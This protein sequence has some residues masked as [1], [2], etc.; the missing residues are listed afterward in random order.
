M[1]SAIEESVFGSYEDNFVRNSKEITKRCWA[2]IRQDRASAKLNEKPCEAAIDRWKQELEPRYLDFVAMA[3]A[4]SVAGLRV[5]QEYGDFLAGLGNALTWANQWVEAE[6]LMSLALSYLPPD[7]PARER[8][9]SAISRFAGEASQERE[10][11]RIRQQELE[12]QRFESLC[13][14]ASSDISHGL[15]LAAAGASIAAVQVCERAYQRYDK[16]VLPW[17]STIRAADSEVG[18][19]CL[20]AKAAAARCLLRI[21]DGFRRCDEP[22]RASDL[23]VVAAELAAQDSEILAE[24]AR[25]H[26]SLASKGPSRST[27]KARGN[28]ASPDGEGEEA[29]RR[30]DTDIELFES[31]CEKVRLRATRSSMC[32]QTYHQYEGVISP[33]LARISAVESITS[34]RA[35]RARTAAASCLLVIAEG[36]KHCDDRGKASSIVAAAAELAPEGSDAAKEIAR[37][38]S[39]LSGESG[40]WSA[41]DGGQRQA[42]SIDGEREKERHVRLMA[43]IEGFEHLCEKIDTDRSSLASVPLKDA[44]AICEQACQRY[45][46]TVLPWLSIICAAG[47]E[48]SPLVLR[49][50]A[51]A[52]QCLLRI[53]EAFRYCHD[54]S[55]ERDLRA[56]AAE[57]APGG[58]G[59]A[60]K[61]AL[62]RGG[63]RREIPDPSTSE[64][65]VDLGP[66]AGSV[67]GFAHR[68]KRVW[69]R[70]GLILGRPKSVDRFVRLCDSLMIKYRQQFQKERAGSTNLVQNV[71]ALKAA[72]EAYK[73]RASPWLAVIL[74]SY[75]GDIPAQAGNAA[76]RCLSCLAD[77]FIWVHELE[78]AQALALQAL[79]LVDDERLETEINGHLVNIAAQKHPT[80]SKATRSPHAHGAT[81]RP[82]A[83]GSR[84]APARTTRATRWLFESSGNSR[85]RLPV[86]LAVGIAVL[87][88]I[89]ILIAVRNSPKWEPAI[90]DL[91][92]SRRESPSVAPES[93]DPVSLANGT[94]LISPPATKGLGQLKISNYTQQDAAVKLKTEAGKVALRFVYIRA[95]SDLTIPKIPVGTYVLEFA[96]GRDWDVA[97]GS[98]RLERAFSRFDEPF[99]FSES[100]D[101]RGTTFSINSVT[102]HAV[103]NGT[104]RTNAIS[105]KDFAADDVPER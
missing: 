45:D 37:Q 38:R 44:V 54:W 42:G 47:P 40:S 31:L 41:S 70:I 16:T 48:A 69:H 46:D 39:Q 89:P 15:K 13:Q 95:M 90:A 78:T 7:S 64:D 19:R 79:P 103:A 14:E 21:A 10:R 83:S 104:A 71:L 68:G 100:S 99:V 27:L 102:L 6:R 84:S 65:L 101:A 57:L 32:E 60:K 34:P 85:F 105:A 55:R 1:G 28:S 2:D 51:A 43:E 76:A 87:I 9:Q 96:T 50:K 81:G 52:S 56:A 73:R 88:A 98:F 75:S 18:P 86:I 36:F 58:A 3:D 82:N 97:S 35:V 29:R 49:A 72:Y 12:L 30:K 66:G 61:T 80:A 77:G 20:S 94:D 62:E 26:P 8:I 25:H 93:H 53:A 11:E 24:I 23:M 67:D 33:W 74:E 59:L 91:E 17:L 5:R 63:S 22:A 4:H 92:I